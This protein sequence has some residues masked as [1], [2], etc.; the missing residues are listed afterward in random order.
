M[1]PTPKNQA[2]ALLITCMDYRFVDAF[3]REAHVL[4]IDHSYDRVAVAGDIKNVV[5]PTRSNDDEL[6]LRQIEIS[7][8]L[9]SIEEVVIIA[10]QNCG[11]YTELQGVSAED[12]LIA[13]STDLRRA[14]QIILERIPGLK[15]ICYFATLQ[16][17]DHGNIIGFKEIT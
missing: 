14:R 1:T 15:V 13:H 16:A 10:H 4:G 9:H 6:I 2:K 8:E 3:Y 5:R 17:G 11:A 7:K 12:E